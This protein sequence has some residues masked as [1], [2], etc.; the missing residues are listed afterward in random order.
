MKILFFLL[1]TS[2]F[3]FNSGL[4]FSA[5]L[6]ND[7]NTGNDFNHKIT[8]FNL[9]LSPP[10]SFELGK[11]DAKSFY[12]DLSPFTICFT[13]GFFAPPIGFATA[14]GMS[15]TKPEIYNLGIPYDKRTN[16]L[17]NKYME[18]YLKTAQKQKA[19]RSWAGFVTGTVFLVGGLRMF[20]YTPKFIFSR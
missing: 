14:L 7:E 5:I 1:F 18:G 8:L 10:D 2:L 16:I 9:R 20:G 3:I 13:T 11:L 15:F 4:T 19:I 12:H 17:S 6:T